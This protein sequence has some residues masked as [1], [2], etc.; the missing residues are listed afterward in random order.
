MASSPV[1]NRTTHLGE[2]QRRDAWWLE[3]L[4]IIILFGGFGIYATA[5]AFEGKF[6]EWGPYLSPFYSPLL[7]FSWW[8]FSPA[9]LILGAPLGF[10]TTC[11]YY[12]KAYYRAF[13]LDPPACT[14]GE[15]GFRKN[16]SG[17]RRFPF[18]LQNV[19]RYFLY[20]AI[21][22][23]C[24]LW[25][26]AIR[27]FVFDGKFGIGLGTLIMLLDV[28][29][30]TAYTF[31]CHSLRHIVGGKLDCF[32]CATFGVPRHSAWSLV[33]VLNER[34]M[35][36]AW[37]SLVSVGATDFYIRMLASGAFKDIRIL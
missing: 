24:F 21:L 30:L 3:L 17:E 20:L 11:Y 34:H 37:A 28:C 6:Y 25:Y 16:Y 5:R 7:S 13:F 29:L 33:S 4:P 26:D 18:I 32:S 19:H 8:R 14:V 2:T 15:P 31:S 27:A 1:P 35:I 23:L 9:L 36:F 10:R 12:R 22:F